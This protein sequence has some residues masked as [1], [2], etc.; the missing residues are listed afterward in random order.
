MRLRWK[1][2]QAAEIRWW[3]HYLKDKPTEQYLVQKKRYWNRV[4]RQL[5]L[6]LEPQERILDA[7]CGPAGIFIIL[8]ENEVDA[9]DPLLEAYEN[10]LSHFQRSNYPNVRF[11]TQ[12]LEDFEGK[13]QYDTIFCLN[14][15]NHVDDIQQSLE[16]LIQLIKPGGRLLLSVDAHNY[17]FFKFLF[18]LIPGD[19]LHPHQYDIKEYRTL[20]ENLG[21]RIVDVQN[22]KQNFFFDYYIIQ[23]RFK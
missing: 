10:R 8:Q 2:A 20:L 12:R 14:A 6:T 19:V 22:L 3:Q 5:K 13:V 1:L 17:P 11:H 16:R 18:R 15:I 9:L 7:G 23:A 21:C 4:M